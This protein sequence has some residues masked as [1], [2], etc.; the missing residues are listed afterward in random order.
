MNA[1][2]KKWES[3]LMR[4][5]EAGDAEKVNEF[6]DAMGAESRA[7]FNRGNYN[8]QAL[9]KQC[10]EPDPTYRYWLALRDGQ[11]L[12]YVFLAHWNTGVPILGIAVRDDL[13][14]MRLGGYLMDYA[15][16]KAKAAGKGGIFLT[17]HI[18][19]IRGQVLYESRGFECMGTYRNAKEL[20]YLL[21][22]KDEA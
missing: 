21:A 3:L 8:R 10:T 12:G 7:L 15:I 9:L 6:F 20:F 22:F 18:A 13:K 2:A 5:T 16:E 19:N 14:G 1:D 11:M 17:T 4:E